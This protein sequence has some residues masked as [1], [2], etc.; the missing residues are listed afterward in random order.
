M[1][2]GFVVDKKDAAAIAHRKAHLDNHANQCNGNNEKCSPN[3]QAGGFQGS[4][5]AIAHRA[6]QLNSNN[7][8]Y[9]AP[10]K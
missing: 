9:R 4:A 1:L 3:H 6:K 10:K 7:S 5:A 2:F 8:L